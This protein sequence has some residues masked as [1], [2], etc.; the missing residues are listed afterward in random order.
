[1]YRKE[2]L[3]MRKEKSGTV[4]EQENDSSE[5]TKVTR[6]TVFLT[7]VLNYNLD[8]LALKTNL[9]K[10]EHVRRAIAEYLERQG[11]NPHKKPKV[12]ITYGA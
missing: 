9:P 11:L 3:S 10:G 4:S 12:T 8:L 6:T 2:D 7:D 5:T 1:L